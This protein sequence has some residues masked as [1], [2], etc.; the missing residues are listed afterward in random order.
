[1]DGG[2]RCNGVVE[3]RLPGR[4]HA[5]GQWGQV[6]QCVLPHGGLSI[7]HL[8]PQE[9]EAMHDPDHGMCRFVY[10]SVVTVIVHTC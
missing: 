5:A 8:D 7:V 6:P 2:Q 10:G 1:M 4:K 3:P 9:R